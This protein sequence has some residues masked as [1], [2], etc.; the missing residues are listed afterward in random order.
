[1]A[2]QSTKSDQPVQDRGRLAFL[3]EVK[4]R[5]MKD[6][7]RL[8]SRLGALVDKGKT[9]WQEHGDKED[10]NASEVSEFQ[11]TLSLEKNLEKSRQDVQAALRQVEAGTYGVCKNCGNAIE[12]VRLKLVP[13]ATL[14][15]DCVKQGRTTG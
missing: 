6:Y 11:D 10:E 1:M 7:D 4:R 3:G 12:E 15:V 9:V 14:C 5:L 2:N 8:T 13:A